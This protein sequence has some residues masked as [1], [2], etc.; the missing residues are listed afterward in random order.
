MNR[1]AALFCLFY[2]A[3]ILYLSLYPWKFVAYPF[4]RTLVWIPLADRQL[5]LD[6]CLNLMFYMHLGSSAFL[7]F[8]RRARAFIGAIALGTLI[9]FSV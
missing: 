9:S 1:R 2:L 3:G 6:A 4:A 7:T 8:R 5:I